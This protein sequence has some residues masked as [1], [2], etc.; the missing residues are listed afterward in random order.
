MRI[1][2]TSSFSPSPK[3]SEVWSPSGTWPVTVTPVRTAIPRLVNERTMTLATSVSQPGRIFGRASSKL[4]SD[5]EVREHGGELAADG[6]RPDHRRRPGELAEVQQLVGGED[7]ASVHLK[8]GKAPRDRAGRQHD[9]GAR[10]PAHGAV[11]SGHLD[12]LAGKETAYTGQGGD[13]ALAHQTGKPLIELVDD[14]VLTVLADR[15]LDDGLAGVDPELLRALDAAEE[16]RRL[17]ELLR[18]HT[19]AV[20]AGAA[21]LVLLDN[22]HREAGGG[23]VQRRGVAS[24]AATYDDDV[25]LRRFS[26]VR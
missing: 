3:T 18:G 2:S 23:P 13:L 10:Q 15:E 7:I 4:T 24:R 25:V 19:A 20:K 26:C 6:A 11:G 22:G 14:L 17:E 1:F 16:R 5:A 12:D 9:V 8:A 21:N